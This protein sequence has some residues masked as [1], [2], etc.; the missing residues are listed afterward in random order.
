LV[1]LQIAELL[2]QP[3]PGSETAAEPAVV[4]VA[5]PTRVACVSLA[6][7]VAGLI[8]CKIG[9]SVGYAVGDGDV[10]AGPGTRVVFSTAGYLARHFGH[11]RLE[12]STVLPSR[13]DAVIVD[14]VHAGSEDMQLLFLV[15]RAM[16]R[17]K[18]EAPKLALMSATLDPACFQHAALFLRESCG[19][20]ALLNIGTEK[21]PVDVHHAVALPEEL[22][23]VDAGLADACAALCPINPDV[24]PG[25]LMKAVVRLVTALILSHRPDDFSS[26]VLVF[27]PGFLEIDGVARMM[28]S[29]AIASQW[30]SSAGDGEDDATE[31]MLRLRMA[32]ET[33][34]EVLLVHG[35]A[36]SA[37]SR[38][39][40]RRKLATIN[41]E[42]RRSHED[43]RGSARPIRVYLA[44]NV[45]ESSVT[46]PD[47][48]YV[49]DAALTR[50]NA[51]EVGDS[52]LQ[53]QLATVSSVRQRIG[54]VGRTGPGWAVTFH[55][56]WQSTSESPVE[57]KPWQVSS[58]CR[59]L[60]V[61]LG[62]PIVR[63]S[64]MTI[65]DCICRD[66][67]SG[68]DE[69][70]STLL[71]GAEDMGVVKASGTRDGWLAL[72]IDHVQ[73]S[74]VGSIAIDLPL[75]LPLARFV[76]LACLAGAGAHAVLAV[77]VELPHPA[78]S[79][80]PHENVVDALHG[81]TTFFRN[82]GGEISA[83]LGL[84]CSALHRSW[85][86]GKRKDTPGIHLPSVRR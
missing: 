2:A 6:Q 76:A 21:F 86:T 62:L 11:D 1:P 58:L 55:P 37:A 23:R 33:D 65:G 77:A 59:A 72:R 66:L 73:A 36:F 56:A 40:M 79:S 28:A 71:N 9:T 20:I 46:L 68:S 78:G 15:L 26:S 74:H 25:R 8:G 24:H 61:G 48:R 18:A 75:P 53:T 5:Q 41:A 81:R 10:V 69:Q 64:T 82:L 4:W 19:P 32:N 84:P 29:A 52:Q 44:T 27:L 43:D 3:L 38:S 85:G 45:F 31:D 47:V 34:V 67:A 70:V 14:E 30:H 7:H 17:G 12:S 80:V 83:T 35:S 16:A 60:L 63:S 51:S 49:V 54:R 42:H 39:A 13:A 22:L 57:V 50:V